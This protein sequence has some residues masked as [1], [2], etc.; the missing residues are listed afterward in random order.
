MPEH[1]GEEEL[2]EIPPPRLSYSQSPYKLDEGGK[3][4]GRKSDPLLPGPVFP[5]EGLYLWDE[6]CG[7]DV[8]RYL[9]HQAV[10]F[11][12]ALV[13]LGA[14]GGVQQTHHRR[15]NP[16]FLDKAN[17]LFKNGGGGIIK[18]DDKASIDLH[19]V[20]LNLLD[21]GQKVQV[22][23]MLLAAFH[24]AVIIRGLNAYKHRVKPHLHHQAHQLLIA[25]QV[26]RYLGRE[27]E[28]VS[29]LLHPSVQG[30]QDFC[31]YFPLVAYEVIVHHKYPAPPAPAVDCVQLRQQLVLVFGP[32]SMPIEDDDI[33]ELT[34]IWAA[35]RILDTHESIVLHIQQLPQGDRALDNVRPIA[36]GISRSGIAHFQVFQEGR[37]DGFGLAQQ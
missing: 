25:G 32:G 27:G 6:V 14:P 30:G 1:G 37:Q 4:I 15:Y 28:G 20:V 12:E 31:P 3:G 10:L 17:L 26:Y 16:A 34:V 2:P 35:P 22:T 33:A 29:F 23:V 21:G 18:P 36:A 24:Q 7:G 13:Q 8:P 9:L 11:L 19:A 5:Q